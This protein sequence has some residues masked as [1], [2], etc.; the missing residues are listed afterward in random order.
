MLF[1]VNLCLVGD[2]WLFFVDL[3]LFGNGLVVELVIIVFKCVGF[4][5][6]F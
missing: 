1:V 6:S 3:C 2:F 5:L 4:D